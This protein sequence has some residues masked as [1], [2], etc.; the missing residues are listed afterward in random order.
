MSFARLAACAALVALA[1]MGVPGLHAQQAPPAA[2]QEVPEIEPVQVPLTADM[3]KRFLASYPEALKLDQ[4]LE[5]RRPAPP[6]TDME[7]G[8]PFVLVPHLGDPASVAE[9]NRMLGRFGFSSYAEWS[10]VAYS[11]ELAS[12]ALQPDS[13]LDDLDGQKAEALRDIE[14]D[15]SLSAEEKEAAKLE[16]ESQFAAL[17]E[18][19]PLPGNVEIVK[20]LIDQIRALGA[21]GGN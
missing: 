10:S 1:S 18:F 3:V 5:K 12:E 20:P 13:G 6:T 17:A 4:E 14:N 7:E 8:A 15:K 9:I 21:S 2:S 16:L 19:V 11:I